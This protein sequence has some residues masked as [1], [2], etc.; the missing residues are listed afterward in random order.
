MLIK[1]L[2]LRRFAQLF[3]LNLY[4]NLNVH[5][6]KIVHVPHVVEKIVEK[7]VPYPVKEY[8]KVSVPEPYPV[9]KIVE[10]KVNFKY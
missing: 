4:T 10:K 2:T 1:L 9:E 8:I 5:H 7:R 6:F 3:E